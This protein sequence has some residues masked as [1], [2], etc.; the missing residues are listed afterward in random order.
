MYD[1]GS[2]AQPKNSAVFAQISPDGSRLTELARKADMTP[3]QRMPWGAGAPEWTT[4]ADSVARICLARI[5]SLV[6]VY[7][8]GSAALGGFGPASDLDVLVIADSDADWPD[9]GA[10]LLTD[11]PH[12]RPLELSVVAASDA[13]QP[14]PPWP[15]HLHVNSGES[16]FGLGAGRGDPDLIAH[17]AVTRAAGIPIYGPSAETV[18]GPIPRGELVDYLRGELQWGVDA[19]DQRYAVLNACRAVAYAQ[20]G[21]LLSKLDGGRWWLRQLGADP[22]VEE[23]LTAQRDG[24]D[25]GRSSPE[26]RSFVAAGIALLE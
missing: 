11:R 7:V 24:R 12:D 15:Y 22:L 10:H 14:S 4:Q 19:A 16:R 23:A 21:Q 6:G 2:Q 26:A 3:D 18:I 5:P 25:L 1:A 20:S 17:Y 8:H 9:V 13:S